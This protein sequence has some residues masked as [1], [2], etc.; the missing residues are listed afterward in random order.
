MKL[1]TIITSTLILAVV[2]I[3]GFI[4]LKPAAPSHSA[5]SINPIYTFVSSKTVYCISGASTQVVGTSSNRQF[6]SISNIS[7]TSNVGH[8]DLALGVAA[9]ANTG[10]ALFSSTTQQFNQN[11]LFTGAIYC[12]GNG[13]AGAVSVSEN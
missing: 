6:L 9:A 5:G 1:E 8:V 13:G 3:G 11:N 7:T 10:I 4:A 2:L 12:L